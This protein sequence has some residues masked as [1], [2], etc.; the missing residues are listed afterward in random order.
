MAWASWNVM[1]GDG[2]HGVRHLLDE[3]AAEACRNRKPVFVTL[4]PVHEPAKDK[5]F[6]VYEFDH[7]MYDAA[8][9]A[10]RRVGAARAGQGRAVLRRRMAGRWLPRSRPAHGAGGGVCAGRS[11]AVA[12]DDDSR[13]MH[14]A[15]SRRR[16]PAMRP[17]WKR[18][19]DMTAPR[20][21]TLVRPD[22]AHARE[23][24]QAQL[25]ASHRHAGDRHRPAGG[26]G[27]AVEAVL[28][29]ARQHDL[30][31]RRRIMARAMRRCRCGPG[32]R[33]G[34][35]KPGIDLGRRGDPA[36]HLSARAGLWLCA[37]L[38]VAGLRT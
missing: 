26:S 6:G 24:V 38:G 7:P 36:A 37:D 16:A 29:R 31:P 10:A 35:L 27:R 11:G 4:N 13:R 30:L 12:G 2:R 33:R 25:L 1:K 22:G 17:C 9:A 34:L 14:A 28:G 32:R 8:S 23:A 15:P 5:T 3:P 19:R 18:R 20:S 21:A